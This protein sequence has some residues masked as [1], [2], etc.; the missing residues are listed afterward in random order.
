MAVGKEIRTKINS[1]NNTRKITHAME[2]MATS[3]MRKAQQQMQRT[4]PYADK[5]KSVISHLARGNPE[6]LHPFMQ[7]REVKRIGMIVVSSDRGLCGALNANL[8]R[9]VAHDLKQYQDQGVEVDLAVFG[10]KA[11]GF[12]SRFG[13][14][15]VAHATE[16][17]DRPSIQDI[18]GVVKVM[19]DRYLNGEIDDLHLGYNRFVSTMVQQ[20]TIDDLL[21][22]VA[23]PE[24][25]VQLWDYIY[26]PDAKLLLDTLLKRYIESV[27]YQAVVE[28]IAC[29]Q[30][31]CMIAMKNA[32]DNA[33]NLIDELR[34]AYNKARQAAITT[35]LTEIVAGAEAV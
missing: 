11:M 6:Y 27:I 18:I 8:F 12:F 1:I 25:D 24:K 5:I 19:L 2:K 34:L 22:I 28:N 30:A 31:A 21:P 32:T 9:K 4:R 13:C 7:E 33:G 20:P 35:E 15:I 14:N 26:E 16:L 29:E 10:R 23:E 3:K 17:G